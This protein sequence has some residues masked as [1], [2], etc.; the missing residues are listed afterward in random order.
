[1][2][3]LQTHS[4]IKCKD[5]MAKVQGP[6][7]SLNARGTFGGTLTY[8]G[9]AGT[10]AVF[11]PKTPYDP[12][13]NPQMAHREY[14]KMGVSYWHGLPTPYKALWSALVT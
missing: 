7:F 9:R 6:L 11:L 3:N 4:I 13:S 12:K 10:T 1:M 5:N 14:I 2:V 8:Q